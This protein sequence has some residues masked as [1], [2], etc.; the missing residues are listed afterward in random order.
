MWQLHNRYNE[1]R[2]GSVKLTVAYKI[3]IRL[4]S[5]IVQAKLS[6]VLGIYTTN[7]DVTGL[8][9]Y[10]CLLTIPNHKRI[11]INI[12]YIISNISHTFF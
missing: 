12:F 9:K 3:E 4:R 7:Q 2:T 1:V 11:N 5:C 10:F 8:A 6:S